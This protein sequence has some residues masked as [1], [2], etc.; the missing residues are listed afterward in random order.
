MLEASRQRRPR[1]NASAKE[2]P[3]VRRPVRTTRAS[4]TDDENAPPGLLLGLVS[5]LKQRLQTLEL[6]LERLRQENRL[7]L[8]DHV[9]AAAATVQPAAAERESAA[10]APR[11]E[12]ALLR[13]SVE[14]QARHIDVLEARYKHLEQQAKA[15]SALYLQTTAK[16]QTLSGELF[17][18]REQIVKQREV[19]QTHENASARVNDLTREL[20]LLRSENAA[21]N[22]AVA[23]LSSR[24]FDALSVD[25]QQK[26]LYIASLEDENRELTQKA[27]EAQEAARV[28]S[29]TSVKT[30]NRNAKLMTQMDDLGRQLTQLSVQCEQLQ[31]NRDVA[32]LQLRFYTG[33]PED[34]ELMEA[35]GKALKQM[36]QSTTETPPV[37]QTSRETDSSCSCSREPR[38]FER[39]RLARV[40]DLTQMLREDAQEQLAS[41]KL[42]HAQDIHSLK[43][44]RDQ[45]EL[46]ATQYLTQIGELQRQTGE[47]LRQH[48][49]QCVR[50]ASQSIEVSSKSRSFMAKAP[51]TSVADRDSGNV[52][53]IVFTDLTLSGCFPSKPSGLQSPMGYVII[54]DFYD[55]ES[56]LSPLLSIPRADAMTKDRRSLRLA[57]DF[58]FSFKILLDAAFFSSQAARHVTIELHEVSVGGSTV[59]AAGVLP[60]EPLFLSPEAHVDIRI[61]LFNPFSQTVLATLRTSQSLE[62]PVYAT[63]KASMNAQLHGSAHSLSEGQTQRLMSGHAWPSVAAGL[64]STTSTVQIRLISV[65]LLPTYAAHIGLD[66]LRL[67]FRFM[68][69]PEVAVALAASSAS[70]STLSGHFVALDRC[71]TFEIDGP[72]PHL[73]SFLESYVMHLQLQHACGSDNSDGSRAVSQAAVRFGSLMNKDA[74]PLILLPAVELYDRKKEG[75]HVGRIALEIHLCG[76]ILKKYPPTVDINQLK[77]TIMRL[78]GATHKQK[79]EEEQL[80]RWSDVTA[81]LNLS[82]LD[83]SLRQLLVEKQTPFDESQEASSQLLRALE[84]A[85][86]AGGSSSLGSVD[87][88]D[89]WL[90]SIISLSRLDL[91]VFVSGLAQSVETE[92]LGQAICTSKTSLT[93]AMWTKLEHICRSCD[94]KWLTIEY[95]V[96]CATNG[97]RI[98]S[99]ESASELITWP[100]CQ[101]RMAIES[102][103]H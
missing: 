51:P 9:R 41:L 34:R 37:V 101:R 24:P 72:S 76:S 58:G 68:G 13:T 80:I 15:K 14:C 5:E 67:S 103:T 17:D 83:R 70:Q 90:G 65:W 79:D 3:R 53:E 12:L 62:Q 49:I 46:R 88:L 44:E 86:Q 11:N 23:T 89:A 48:R 4:Q 97:K 99:G 32:E 36:K 8:E 94:T 52:M 63:Y 10:E 55:F 45:W 96:F 43:R 84:K 73:R 81:V 1:P 93:G 47:L 6:D 100:E 66:N 20:H 91:D 40:S 78:F 85:K 21:L 7:L 54:C 71:Q 59:V 39:D 57:M 27:K 38:A 74:K 2:T 33:N 29:Q 98:P 95:Q 16:L 56:Q 50:P 30:R 77:L 69:F 87:A 61:K 42:L 60:L 25:L 28:A 18:A 26:T 22:T 82:P 102:V 92:M 35:V 75:G 31:M 19:I 64:P